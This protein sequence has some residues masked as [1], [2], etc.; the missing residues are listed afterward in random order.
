[1]EKK[2]FLVLYLLFVLFFKSLSNDQNQKT[3]QKIK[4]TSAILSKLVFFFY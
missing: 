1:M 3:K 4:K 2:I